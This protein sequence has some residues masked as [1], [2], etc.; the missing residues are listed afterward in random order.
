MK[1]AHNC[2]RCREA[3]RLG[4]CDVLAGEE[5]ARVEAHLAVCADCRRFA[6]ELQAATTGLRWLATRP[7]EP[8]PGFRARWTRAV[9]EAA[10]PG[11]VS[12]AALALVSWWRAFLLR[13]L[14]PALGVASLWIL[15]LLFRLSAPEVGP[16]AHAATARSPLEIYRALETGEQM[17]ARQL[18]K[19]TPVRIAPPD[20]HPARPR[21]QGLPSPPTATRAE[22]RPV[23]DNRYRV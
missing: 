15:T 13:N 19:E 21:S 4:A 7:A 9:E 1:A 17:L 8:S 5:A 22:H 11:S 16:P 2:R 23:A 14:R 6:E 12:E 18:E 10:W 20:T 3:I